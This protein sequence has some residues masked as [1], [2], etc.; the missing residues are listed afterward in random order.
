MLLYFLHNCFSVHHFWIMCM[1]LICPIA[2]EIASLCD[3]FQANYLII[4]IH[5]NGRVETIEIPF[6][7]YYSIQFVKDILCE[8]QREQGSLI[9]TNWDILCRVFQTMVQFDYLCIIIKITNIYFSPSN[10]GTFKS[11]KFVILTTIC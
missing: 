11:H 6:M 3:N 1:A 10:Y 5:K 8:I 9:K 2:A 7:I 4:H